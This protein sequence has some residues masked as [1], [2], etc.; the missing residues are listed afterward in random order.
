MDRGSLLEAI[1]TPPDRPRH[2]LAQSPPPPHL[3]GATHSASSRDFED[4]FVAWEHP[5]DLQ[6]SMQTAQV[7]PLYLD[8]PHTDPL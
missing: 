1:S 8:P 3:Q 4:D 2:Q 6:L 5:L 7:D